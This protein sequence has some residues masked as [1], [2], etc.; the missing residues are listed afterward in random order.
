MYHYFSSN[1]V[2]SGKYQHR[3]QVVMKTLSSDRSAFPVT[4]WNRDIGKISCV[5]R[6]IAGQSVSV[7]QFGQPNGQTNWQQTGQ[8]TDAIVAFAVSLCC[9]C[10]CFGCHSQQL[11]TCNQQP[12]ST[13]CWRCT[14]RDFT[15]V[16]FFCFLPVAYFSTSCTFDWL[17]VKQIWNVCG[18]C[19]AAPHF[20]PLI[21]SNANTKSHE[22]TSC[23]RCTS[24][25]QL[26]PHNS[27]HALGHEAS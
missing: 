26:A 16:L 3:Q 27:R 10:C 6:R 14:C 9:C 8:V 19:I 18:L 4:R 20:P 11:A 24:H 25:M 23:N 5:R 22:L 1:P 21:V 2:K 15:S 7:P 17:I 13:I 12:A